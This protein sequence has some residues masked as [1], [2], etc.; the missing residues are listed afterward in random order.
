MKL[1]NGF[2]S[3]SSS[4]SF[5]IAVNPN[6]SKCEHCKATVNP[7]EI[8]GLL[9]NTLRLKD[10]RTNKVNYRENFQ[11]LAKNVI[12]NLDYLTKEL[13]EDLDYISNKRKDAKILQ[14]P[15]IS[16]LICPIFDIIDE[17]DLIKRDHSLKNID[18]LRRGHEF[19]NKDKLIEEVFDSLDSRENEIK[20][21]LNEYT[22]LLEKFR[23]YP[24][25]EIYTVIDLTDYIL[26]EALDKLCQDGNT[27]IIKEDRN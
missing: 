18:Y 6:V 26:R 7:I 20:S 9:F 8:F 3:N 4:S 17:I 21:K 11:G 25:W 23:K 13:K 24:D 16:E 22:E 2:V 14:N 1:R 19:L 15:E 12:E 5:I 27:V 10:K